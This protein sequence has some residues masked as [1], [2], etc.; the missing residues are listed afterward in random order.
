MPFSID[1]DFCAVHLRG[2]LADLR[3]CRHSPFFAMVL[4]Y[5]TPPVVDRLTTQSAHLVGRKICHV[6]DAV[7][8][9][10]S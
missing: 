2:F 9:A 7:N 5:A 8:F 3:N 1:F 6:A 4:T 10:A